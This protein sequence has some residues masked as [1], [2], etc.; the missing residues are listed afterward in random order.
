[1]GTIRGYYPGGPDRTS[2]PDARRRRLEPVRTLWSRQSRK[3]VT[4]GRVRRR[5]RLLTGFAVMLLAA[6]MA[7][8]WLGVRSHASAEEVA[9]EVESAAVPDTPDAR[10]RKEADRVLQELWRMEAME[11]HP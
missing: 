7:G 10:I 9:R 6:V 3:V 8:S 1:M 2:D 5:R 11:R 4:V